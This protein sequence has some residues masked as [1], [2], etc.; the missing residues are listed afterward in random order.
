MAA[1]SI[2]LEFQTK[3]SQ[4]VHDISLNGSTTDFWTWYII[5]LFS[6]WS[7]NSQYYSQSDQSILQ[8]YIK[9]VLKSCFI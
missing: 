8:K 1:I 4:E 9:V 2:R 7:N 3:T 6:Q 5:L